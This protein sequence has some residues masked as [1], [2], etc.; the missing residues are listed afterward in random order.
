MAA[1]RKRRRD[2]FTTLRI[3]RQATGICVCI[4]WRCMVSRFSF[5]GKKGM[6][7]KGGENEYGDIDQ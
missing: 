4:L 5:R 6:F 7:K 2:D 1:S 3:Y